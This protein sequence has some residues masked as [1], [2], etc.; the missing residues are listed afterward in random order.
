MPLIIHRA[1]RSDVLAE[2][3]AGLLATPP[4]D[5]FE[6][7]VVVVAANGLQ[8]WLAQTVSH[9]LGASDGRQDGICAG[10]D[11]VRPAHLVSELTDRDRDDPWSPGRLAWTLLD[12]VDEAIDEDWLAIVARHVGH[13][14]PP[15]D[16]ALRRSRRF[17]TARRVA[18]LL[19]GY[20]RQRPWMVQAWESGDDVDGLGGELAPEQRWQA[21][22]WRRAHARL[23]GTPSPD[24]RLADTAAALRDGSLEPDLPQ[25][26]SLVGHTRMPAAELDVVAAL[27]ER[28][29]VHLWLPHPS[30][31]RW[32]A[33]GASTG[34]AAP[35]SLS[36]SKGRR[37]A[38]VPAP[39]EGNTLLTA[40]GRDVTELQL[41]LPADAVVDHRPGPGRPDT[42]L[43]LL[44]S[45][46]AADRDG[47]P[48]RTL[49]PAD[50][51]VQVHACHGPARQVD[52]LRE[53]VVG[54]LADDP[55]LE[56][57]DVLVMCPDVE[58]YAPLVQAAFG[59]DDVPGVQHPAHRLRVRIADRAT[60]ATNP[61]AEALRAVV[62]LAAGH[63]VTATEVRDLVALEPVRRR[64]GLSDDDLERI[65]D[66]L[67]AT[68]VRWGLDADDRGAWGLAGLS[69]NT[70]R[71]GLDRLAVGVTTEPGGA[72]GPR[73]GGLLPLDDLQ[74]TDID[75]VGRLSEVVARLGAVVTGPTTRSR[76][77]WAEQLGHAVRALT[78][79]T[80]RDAWQLD[81]VLR[82][83][84]ELAEGDGD[85]DLTVVEVGAVLDDLFAARP[86]RTSFRTGSLTVCTMVPMRSVPHRVVC[87]LGLDADAFPRTPTPLGD[88]VLARDPLVGERDAAAEDRQL[89]L[90]AVLSATEH[91]VVTYTGAS[92]HT[93]RELPPATPVGE[94]LDQLERTVPGQG[95]RE[96]VLV[97]HPLQSFDPRSFTPGGVVAGRPFSFDPVA[98]A[99]AQA[100]ER[101]PRPVQP[102][103][104]RPLEPVSQDVVTLDELRAFVAH[105]VRTFFRSRLDVLVPSEVEPPPDGVPLTLDHLEQ[106][107]VKDRVLEAVLQG[108]DGFDAEADERRRGLVP[109]GPLGEQ[110]LES[111]RDDL[112][113]LVQL[114]DGWRDEPATSR[115]VD[116]ELPDG[117]RVVGTVTDLRPGHGLR[118][119]PSKIQGGRLT[120]PWVD[121][122][123]LAASGDGV[124]F[125][126]VGRVGSGYRYA[127]GAGEL[128]PPSTDDA[129]A[130]LGELLDLRAQGLTEPLPL[131]VK[132][133]QAYAEGVRVNKPQVASRRAQDEWASDRFTG[134]LREDD[135][136]YHRLAFGADATVQ[137]LLDRGLERHAVRLWTPLLD[138]W[139]PA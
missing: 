98:Y 131:P 18:T 124:P 78:D 20:A 47:A 55:T 58:A 112:A 65:D 129:L 45:D 80:A 54:L 119:T 1:E 38:D 33:V 12:V 122:L 85:G 89:F 120:R 30:R 118:V 73:P 110:L 32:E 70:W 44:Q 77:N 42:L 92:E 27:G 106:W 26:L 49:D 101:P 66:W 24:H 41:A 113:R 71:S 97:R 59:L 96:H 11:F 46:L 56:P 103:L 93:G 126:L 76:G 51:S 16:E 138:R 102:F 36:L 88:D 91:L 81:Q 82:G 39:D 139:G 29:D 136:P 5:P 9:R 28:R 53:V 37:R 69:Q 4:H 13:G 57:R 35:G 2:G 50:G 7:D 67:L 8:R 130:L 74:S 15:A 114:T 62:A 104:A 125:R 60:G 34:S 86:T 31:V 123:A 133:S 64:F 6:R 127:P 137:D 14:L 22:L 75:L 79:T 61:V 63:R 116:V 99:G 94:L 48:G 117:R 107:Q 90:D 134:F 3:L 21:E 43:G 121:V 87:L 108:V 25:R 10:V 128:R 84:A 17:P 132:T 105:P 109:P 100:V 19:H 23:A 68:A 111:F 72:D 95:V 52:V 135:D 115:D 83:L 40:C